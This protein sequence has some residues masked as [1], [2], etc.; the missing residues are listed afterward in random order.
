MYVGGA[1]GCINTEAR[2]GV[3]PPRAGVIREIPEIDAR[4]QSK[5]PARTAVQF[6]TKS[7]LHRKFPFSGYGR[8]V[9]L[10]FSVNL[11]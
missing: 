4:H 5:A 8:P 6:T 11:D 1:F 9:P 10:G 2:E 7:S 3:G